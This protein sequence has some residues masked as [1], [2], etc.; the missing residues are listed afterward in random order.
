MH[1][2]LARSNATAVA[3]HLC[4][5]EQAMNPWLQ[6]WSKP[7]ATAAWMRDHNPLYGVA[8][9]LIMLTALSV[10]SAWYSAD[11][12]EADQASRISTDSDAID[13]HPKGRQQSW[14]SNSAESVLFPLAIL[15]LLYGTG[16]CFGGAAT[17]SNVVAVLAWSQLP[18]LLLLLVTL[19]AQML[20]FAASGPILSNEIVFNDGSVT[21]TPPQPQINLPAAIHHLFSAIFIIWSFQILLFAYAEVEAVRR[22]KAVKLITISF[23]ALLL[24]Q[25]L[26][27]TLLGRLNLAYLLGLTDII[28][29]P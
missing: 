25:I 19:G 11:A 7:A 10:F 2:A 29:L 3:A 20:G 22:S 17:L 15:V 1:W 4:A 28:E 23:V 5:N 6:I 8:T 27:D 13:D 9:I 26:V 21:L 16:R 14:L 24:G 18:I 12:A